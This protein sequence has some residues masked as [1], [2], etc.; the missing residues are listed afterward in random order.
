MTKSALAV[1]LQSTMGSKP[2]KSDQQVWTSVGR[3]VN[4]EENVKS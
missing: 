3:V 1:D 4:F 2:V